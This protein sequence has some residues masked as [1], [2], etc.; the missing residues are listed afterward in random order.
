MRKS[1]ALGL[2]SQKGTGFVMRT[3]EDYKE[4]VKNTDDEAAK[5]LEEAVNHASIISA[6][7]K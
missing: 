2:D 7:I 3:W 1:Y 4:H 6:M 5:D